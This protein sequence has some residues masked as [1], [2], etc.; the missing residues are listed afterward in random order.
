MGGAGAGEVSG[1]PDL[2]P[3]TTMDEKPYEALSSS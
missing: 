1:I 3:A 2:Y